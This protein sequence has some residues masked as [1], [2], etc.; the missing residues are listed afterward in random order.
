VGEINLADVVSPKVTASFP[1]FNPG[2][3]RSQR[4]GSESATTLQMPAFTPLRRVEALMA[5]PRVRAVAAAG[6]VLVLALGILWVQRRA[7]HA[8]A[9]H[10]PTGAVTTAPPPIT[11]T[12]GAPEL[13]PVATSPPPS[14]VATRTAP[15]SPIYGPP[16]TASRRASR[17][18]AGVVSAEAP[19]RLSGA[20]LQA[21]VVRSHPRFVACFRQHASE[22]SATTGQ[23]TVEL[24][25]AST[26]QV[27]SASARLPTFKAPALG[28]CL[29]EEALRLRFPRH[30]DHEIRF[31][32]P[33]VYRKGQ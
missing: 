10:V 6:A 1:A 30:A 8:R 28:R 2:D 31:A 26:G 32:F 25:V 7:P 16:T 19:G 18:R 15:P 23:A 24:T 17:P 14:E 9:I 27:S 22:L 29:E 20:A 4:M 13:S 5:L 33:L 21:V 11:R 3:P 12:T